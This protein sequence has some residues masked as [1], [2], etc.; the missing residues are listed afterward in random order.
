MK[1]GARLPSRVCLVASVVLCLAAFFY[2]ALVISPAHAIRAA[3]TGSIQSSPSSGPVGATITVSGSGWTGE[4]GTQ[5][6]F[7]YMTGS[8]CSNVANSQVG[9]I[10]SGSFSGWFSWP[11][12]TPLG[13]YT[14]C[15]ILEGTT[16]KTNT[17]TVLSESVPQISISPTVLTAGK[18]ATITGSNY[19]PAG[20]A[21]QLSWQ[22]VN[23]STADFSIAPTISDSNGSISTTF[24]VPTSTLPSD[25]YMIVATGGGSQPPT[26][27]SSVTF[28]YNAPV[29]TPT[30]APRPS[31]D[32]NPTQ[33]TSP[34]TTATVLSTPLATP[35]IGSTASAVSQN[36]GTSQTPTSNTIVN[37]GSTTATYRPINLFQIAGIAGSLALLVAILTLVLFVRRKKAHTKKMMMRKNP[38]VEPTTYGAM[39]LQNGLGSSSALGNGMPLPMNYGP[40]TT[41]PVGL[42]S[43]ANGG[44]M[45]PVPTGQAVQT[46]KEIQF[47]PYIH[48]LQ[49]PSGVNAGPVEDNSATVLNDPDLEVIKKQVQMGLFATPR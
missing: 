45:N 47:S 32:P 27:S 4:D 25:S 33:N 23:G 5:I 36:T 7:G 10:Q 46:N 49:Q 37:T 39:P 24:T 17:Y 2:T 42:T 21:V 12:G 14:V 34:A 22:T 3:V 28:T 16:Y 30:P 41:I 19:L 18:Q 26:L 20:T 15:A 8:K 40:I 44:S 35:T 6:S 48:L 13:T 1:H 43:S 38:S 29:N 11:Q 31:P 9:T